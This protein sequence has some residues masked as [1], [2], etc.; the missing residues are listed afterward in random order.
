MHD[1]ERSGLP[2]MDEVCMDFEPHIHGPKILQENK[3]QTSQF[4]AC[5]CTH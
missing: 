5:K 2:G 1:Q 3:Q 4:E